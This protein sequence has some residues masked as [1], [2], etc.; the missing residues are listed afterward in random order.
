MK[1]ETD[2]FEL[3]T[4]QIETQLFN[5]KHCLLKPTFSSLKLEPGLYRIVDGELYRIEKGVSI[6]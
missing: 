4:N 1:F 6:L 2:Y 3:G 5:G